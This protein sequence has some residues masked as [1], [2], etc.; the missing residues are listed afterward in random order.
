MAKIGW[1]VRSRTDTDPSPRPLVGVRRS[2]SWLLDWRLSEIAEYTAGVGP[3]GEPV[4]AE[5]LITVWVAVRSAQPPGGCGRVPDAFGGAPFPARGSPGPHPHQP[6][7]AGVLSPVD[8]NLR[9]AGWL[10]WVHYRI[11]WLP[12]RPS[13]TRGH[14]RPGRDR[15]GLGAT[16]L[17][18]VPLSPLATP[19]IWDV[20]SGIA[21]RAAPLQLVS[22]SC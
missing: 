10:N 5:P 3:V 16:R 6:S 19:G 21:T 13:P 22:R 1:S 17:A 18:V 11:M 20:I 15:R 2:K 8:L 9:L 4:I 12:G 7:V 14:A